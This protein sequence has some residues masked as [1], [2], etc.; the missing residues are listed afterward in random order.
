MIFISARPEG[1]LEATERLLHAAGYSG[2]EQLILRPQAAVGENAALF[3][4]SARR[5]LERSGWT[6]V[7]NVGDQDSD[8]SGGHAERTFKLPNPFYFTP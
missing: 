7:A 8:L 2:W 4:A 6:I 5:E 3:K 1:R